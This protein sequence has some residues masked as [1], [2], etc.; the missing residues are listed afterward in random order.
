MTRSLLVLS[1]ILATLLTGCTSST[2]ISPAG[3][4]PFDREFQG[5]R[6]SWRNVDS[7]TFLLYR[8]FNQGGFV[9]VCG[10]VVTEGTSEIR[11]LESQLLRS[12]FLRAGNQTLVNSLSFF[13]R[14][15]PNTP[16]EAL[17]ANCVVTGVAWTDLIGATELTLGS[18]QARF[19]GT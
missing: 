19:Y 16:V 9:K 6:I 13:N 10:V 17:T 18:R 2:Q 7:S 8:T 1:A 12:K 3:T 11:S 15:Q 14:A 4:V 5:G